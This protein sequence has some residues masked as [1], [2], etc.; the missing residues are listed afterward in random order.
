MRT[1]CSLGG[2]RSFVRL[3]GSALAL[4]LAANTAAAQTGVVSGSVTDANTGRPLQQVR[5]Q[6]VGNQQA[7]TATDPSGRF[8][9]RNVPVGDVTLRVQQL[10]YRPETRPITIKS[11]DTVTVDLR[12]SGSAVE[13]EQ[14]VV[15]GTGG[16]AER[17]QVGALIAE[18]DVS[19]LAE[20]VAIPDVGRMLSS[21]VT[22]LRS[23]TVGGGVGTGQ[24]LRIR[25]TA[26]LSLS[27]RPAIYVDGVRVDGRATEWFNSGACCSFG[28]GASTDRLGDLNPERH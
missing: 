15:T 25:G 26:S 20:Q 6:I 1:S 28:G 3:A 16:A 21:K 7:V 4:V 23:T 12:L 24:D 11:N 13:L 10:G 2:T 18:V 5:V 14:V 9:I 19:K 8:L 27:Q 17:R 22:G